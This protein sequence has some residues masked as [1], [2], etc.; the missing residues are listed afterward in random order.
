MKSRLVAIAAVLAIVGLTTSG[1]LPQPDAEPTPSSGFSSEK[2]AFAAAEGTY[3][4]YVDALNGV[5]LSDPKTFEDVYA[6][7]TG[8][9]NATDRKT[10]SQM[11]ADGWVVGGESRISRIDQESASPEL[12]Q[13]E[14]AACVDVSTVTL[15]DADGVSKVSDDRPATQSTRVTLV[16]AESP[17]GFLV[18]DSQGAELDPPC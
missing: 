3:R 14:I 10:F 12:D 13:V 8:D 6:W 7:T 9:L 18:A 4:A 5:D 15:I 1:C 11:H 17:T 16:K 2:E